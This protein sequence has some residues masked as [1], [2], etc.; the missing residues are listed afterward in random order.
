MMY[1]SVDI[2]FSVC[3]IKFLA[4]RI[5]QTLEFKLISWAT[6]THRCSLNDEL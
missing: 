2:R 5:L 4:I 1:A 3:G 6:K